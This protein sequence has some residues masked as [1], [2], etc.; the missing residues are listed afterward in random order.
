M[1]S[2]AVV[3]ALAACLHAGAWALR[4]RLK[5]RQNDRT[6]INAVSAVRMG[7]VERASPLIEFE[8]CCA[9]LETLSPR[10][11]KVIQGLAAAGRMAK[12]P[13]DAV[14][15]QSVQQNIG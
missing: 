7:A 2:V 10:A 1:R 3:V 4:Q 8:E 11:W 15:A 6:N 14:L 5:H 9:A 12:Q 13:A